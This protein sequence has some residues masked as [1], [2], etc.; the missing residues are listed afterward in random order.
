MQIGDFTNQEKQDESSPS[1]ELFNAILRISHSSASQ[2]ERNGCFCGLLSQEDSHQN[3]FGSNEKEKNASQNKNEAIPLGTGEQSSTPEKGHHVLQSKS[4][5]NALLKAKII[6]HAEIPCIIQAIVEVSFFKQQSIGGLVHSRSGLTIENSDSGGARCDSSHFSR[7]DRVLIH[8]SQSHS[9]QSLSTNRRNEAVRQKI[10]KPKQPK[11]KIQKGASSRR[12]QQTRP[13]AAATNLMNLRDKMMSDFSISLD[14]ETFKEILEW[15]PSELRQRITDRA[16]IE[17]IGQKHPAVRWDVFHEEKESSREQQNTQNRELVSDLQYQQVEQQIKS[18]LNNSGS[19]NQSLVIINENSED[20]VSRMSKN[21]NYLHQYNEN[22]V[23]TA[24]PSELGEQES[25]IVEKLRKLEFKHQSDLLRPISARY[26][27][28]LINF[29]TRKQRTKAGLK[30]SSSQTSLLSENVLGGDRSI[31]GKKSQR[32]SLYR[33]QFDDPNTLFRGGYQYL[34]SPSRANEIELF[35]LQ[36]KSHDE[37]RPHL[38]RRSAQKDILESEIFDQMIRKNDKYLADQTTPKGLIK[39][40]INY[41]DFLH[42]SVSGGQLDAKLRS[43]L[44][45][46]QQHQ[47]HQSII[48]KVRHNRLMSAQ[49]V[50]KS[51]A[52]E[53]GGAQ[54]CEINLQ[55]NNEQ[56]D[57]EAV[58]LTYIDLDHIIILNQSLSQRGESINSKQSQMKKLPLE[59]EIREVSIKIEQPI[60]DSKVEEKPGVTPGTSNKSCCQC[61]IF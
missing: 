1:E 36:S 18:Q 42:E 59:R 57:D 23:I 45:V 14:L 56:S 19:K 25:Y 40:L 11:Q 44:G 16:N 26:R 32:S 33:R 54:D 49:I 28:P 17:K 51:K 8:T 38:N 41:H 20:E 21:Y 43:Q 60:I 52:E 34:L 12:G 7:E 50:Q 46:P 39:Q 61:I 35:R 58:N 3:E 48:G 6:A 27:K 10:S 30:R 53:D 9:S 13:D 2:N 37:H 4:L 31:A 24:K 5:I 29:D 22:A 55:P 15:L 47:N